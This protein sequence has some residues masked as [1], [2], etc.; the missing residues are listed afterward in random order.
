V[1]MKGIEVGHEGCGLGRVG[2]ELACAF[3]L[4]L[5]GKL[6]MKGVPA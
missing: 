6:C 2:K 1:G 3:G 5:V 4:V